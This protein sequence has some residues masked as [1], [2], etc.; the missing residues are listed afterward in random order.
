MVAVI[1]RSSG[2]GFFVQRMVVVMMM[3]VGA[4]IRPSVVRVL[5]VHVR[6]EEDG[7]GRWAHNWVRGPHGGSVVCVWITRRSCWV[8]RNTFSGRVAW[9]RHLNFVANGAIASS[10]GSAVR[11]SGIFE[12]RW[13]A[14]MA[15]TRAC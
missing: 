13:Y 11:V 9:E 6:L 10:V 3:V 12:R 8:A 15:W 7:L 2:L 4:C 14:A 1:S 5:G